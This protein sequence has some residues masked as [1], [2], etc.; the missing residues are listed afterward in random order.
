MI[1]TTLPTF[2]TSLDE[3]TK[4]L[5]TVDKEIVVTIDTSLFAEQRW[6]A[7]FPHNAK[8]ETLFAYVERIQNAGVVGGAN[9]VSDLKALYCFME[10]DEIP[11]FK[12]FLQMFDLADT[13]YLKALSNK[14]KFVFEIALKTAT[15]NAKN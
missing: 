8:N 6:E 15:A 5:V 2:E 4:K 9:I 3:K 13:E 12:S 7:N 11:D 1:K 14:I 10:S